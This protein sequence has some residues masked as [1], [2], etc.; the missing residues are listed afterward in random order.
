MQYFVLDERLE[1]PESGVE[2]EPSGS[3]QRLRRPELWK[4]NVAKR[5]NASGV[6]HLNQEGKLVP[7]RE[8]K[9]GCDNDC[10]LKCQERVNAD[11]RRAFF[12]SYWRQGHRNNKAAL[13]IGGSLQ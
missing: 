4:R 6:E 5:G 12:R 13:P 2:V 9:E 10:R 11:E 1:V 7:P 8:I 3:R